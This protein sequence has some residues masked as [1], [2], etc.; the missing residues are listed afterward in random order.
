MMKVKFNYTGEDIKA[1]N[2]HLFQ[3]SEVHRKSASKSRKIILVFF[4]IF[5]LMDL[6]GDGLNIYPNGIFLAA[7][8]L[9]VVF[10]D[11]LISWTTKRLID[12]VTRV[13]NGVNM[14][15]ESE[16]EFY[17]EFM[18]Y[19]SENGIWDLAYGAVNRME[20]NGD[21][22]YIFFGCEGMIPLNLR[23]F[24]SESEKN[25]WVGFLDQKVAASRQGFLS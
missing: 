24:A 5:L 21:Y 14:L 19:K 13:K 8:L 15:G 18:R 1:F 6:S 2:I 9:G 10:Y 17:E 4:V 16:F 23:A 20:D 11:R 25:S 22:R 12:R 7:M 3:H